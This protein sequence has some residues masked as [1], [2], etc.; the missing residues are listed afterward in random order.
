MSKMN[1]K[2]IVRYKMLNII[3]AHGPIARTKI[4]KMLNE[5]MAGII[6]IAK[7]LIKEG[8]VVESGQINKKTKRKKL[9]CLNKDFY[10]AIGI[11]IKPEKIIGIITNLNGEII[12][13]F[14]VNI[15]TDYLKEKI[16]KIIFDLIE[17][18]LCNIKINSVIGIGLSNLGVLNKE[19]DHV[20]FSSQLPD[21]K[22][23]PI[24]SLIEEKTGLKAYIDESSV[25]NLKGEIWFG[26]I[27]KY[28]NIIYIQL[29]TGIGLSIMSDGIFI[30]GAGGIAGEIAHTTVKPDGDQCYC[31]NVGCLQTVATSRVIVGKVKKILSKGGFSIITNMVD[32]NLDNITIHDIIKSAEREDKIALRVMDEVIRFLG[33]AISNVINLLN[34][35]LVIFG[36]QMIEESD[37]VV[38][39]IERVINKY[40]LQ[41]SSKDVKYKIASHKKDGGA[42]G[43]VTLVLDSFFK[44]SQ[45]RE[46][47]IS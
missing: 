9:L 21:W 33:L 4:Y 14:S 47:D 11:D 2:D 1:K 8:I 6:E 16:I 35:E 27:S 37:Y 31:G 32:D 44:Y 10:K 29:G 45:F 23:I 41:I 36:G 39:P 43:A 19:R 34:P 17:K 46:N 18:L 28:R 13:K 40:A 24:K 12:N 22:N 3:R 15:E 25:L 42:L 7:E 30:R 38:D 20:L 26:G 5:R